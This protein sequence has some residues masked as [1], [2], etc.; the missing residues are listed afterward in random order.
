MAEK[1]STLKP[2]EKN[3]EMTFGQNDYRDYSFIPGRL[4]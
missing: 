1:A 4:A 3:L 2:E